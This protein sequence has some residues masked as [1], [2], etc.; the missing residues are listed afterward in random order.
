SERSDCRHFDIHRS[1]FQYRAKEPDAWLAKLKKALRRV[2]RK[3]PEMG[4]PRIFRLPKGEGWIAGAQKVQRLRRELG[5]M[6]PPKKPRKRRQSISTGLPTTATHR[7]H[8]WTWDFVHNVTMRGGKLRMVT[9][10]DKYTRACRCIHV[11]R[12]I[13]AGKVWQ[14]MARLIEQYKAREHIRSDNGPE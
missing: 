11:D 7:N 14:V 5:R 9:A 8:G 6:V 4:S 2:S 1:T 10:L 13:N 3:H 12:K